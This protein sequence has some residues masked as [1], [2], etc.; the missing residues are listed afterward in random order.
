[1][2]KNIYHLYYY[3]QYTAPHTK[4]EDANQQVN[5]DIDN[6]ENFEEFE[7]PSY[8]SE[9]EVLDNDDTFEKLKRND[10]AMIICNPSRIFPFPNIS[11]F[12]Y[13]SFNSCMI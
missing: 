4:M 6:E 8:D 5:N 2:H 1:M 9:G 11:I 12:S 7:D 13:D 3:L 10:P